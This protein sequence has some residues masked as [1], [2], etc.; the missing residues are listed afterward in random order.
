MSARYGEK[1]RSGE[2]VSNA[3]RRQ[4]TG[5]TT[6]TGYEEVFTAPGTWTWPGNVTHVEV[7]LVGGGGGGGASKSP[8][9][10]NNWAGG[11]GGG[12]VRMVYDIPVSAPVPITVGAGGAGGTYPGGVGLAGGDSAF[13]PLA[14]P[15]PANTYKVGGGGGGAP[16]E[17]SPSY[18][19]TSS[20][21][22]PDGGGGGGTS[23][24]YTA[25]LYSFQGG[26]YGMPAS[27][28]PTTNNPSLYENSEGCGGG[29]LTP[30][31]STHNGLGRYGYG[32]AQQAYNM[33]FATAG[34]LLA[35]QAASGLS[36]TGNGAGAIKGQAA[37][38]GGTGGSGIVIVRWWE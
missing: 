26:L 31:G 15:I 16:A 7:L 34:Q 4:I 21:A 37:I 36:N 2:P 33:I 28:N 25:G 18:T 14:P 5:G 9:G 11:G 24:I 8:P 17:P 12:G 10:T 27:D 32:A 35:T 1:A 3:G 13:G 38:P 22:P 19:P 6:Q 29:A 23:M 20:A 30:G